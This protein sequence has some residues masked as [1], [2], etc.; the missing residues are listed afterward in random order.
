MT[1][2]IS[3]YRGPLRRPVQDRRK[4]LMMPL[5]VESSVCV[6]DGCTKKGMRNRLCAAHRKR[7]DR[8]GS[9]HRVTP[10]KDGQVPHK[11]SKRNPWG[12]SNPRYTLYVAL[13]IE[14]VDRRHG[15]FP[16]DDEV[17]PWLDCRLRNAR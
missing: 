1:H 16:D 9:P 14:E 10:L 3:K 17:D 13:L 15:E 11:Y 7:L 4:D 2:H 5:T 6:V 12:P 8:Y